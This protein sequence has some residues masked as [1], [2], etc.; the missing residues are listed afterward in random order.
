L[1]LIKKDERANVNKILGDLMILVHSY[2]KSANRFWNKSNSNTKT[3][4]H[5][6]R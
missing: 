1:A 4:D 2:K 5:M 6:I 3:K